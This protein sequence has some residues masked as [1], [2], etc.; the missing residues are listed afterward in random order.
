[1]RRISS[2]D[3]IVVGSGAGGLAAAAILARFKGWR[4]LVLE[5]HYEIGGL[6][7][8]FRR[9]PFSWDVGLHYVGD[10]EQGSLARGV[11]DY[12]TGG[13]LAW[14]AM[15]SDFE[16]VLLPGLD[17]KVPADLD[18][19]R[20]RLIAAFPDEAEAIRRYFRDVAHA[21]AWLASDMSLRAAPR[22]LVAA[23]RALNRLRAGPA[24][25]TTGAYL[26]RNFRSPVLKAL[27][28]YCWGD[29]GVPPS[30]SAFAI[31]ALIV[32]HYKRG[33][34]YPAGGAERFAR[35]AEREIERAGGA[36][37]VQSEVREIL[38]DGG[39]ARGVRV[40]HA[41]SGETADYFAPVVI[42][43]AGALATFRTLVSEEAHPA[44]GPLARRLAEHDSGASAIQVFLGLK[45][46]PQTLGIKGENYWLFE[47]LD[48]E[49]INEGAADLEN[50]RPLAAY[51]SFP[52]MKAG[53][54]RPPTAEILAIVAP[55]FFERWRGASDR[56]RRRGYAEA[57]TRIADGLIAIADRHIPGLKDLIEYAE[58]ATP[59]TLE[60]YDARPGGRMYGLAATPALLRSG[61]VGPRTPILGLYIAG[62]DAGS[63]GMV[64]AA[65]GGFLAAGAA[66]GFRSMGALMSELR[67]TAPAR[68]AIAH[69]PSDLPNAKFRG[70]V[71][72]RRALNPAVLELTLELD[73]AIDETP[74]RYLRIEVADAVWRDYSIAS[75]EG[76]RV[77]LLIDLRPDGPG[78][79]WARA[80]AIGDSVNLRGPIGDF[81]PREE[82]AAVHFV[83]TGTGLAPVLPMIARLG[84]TNDRRPVRLWFG[85]RERAVDLA[86]PTLAEIRL[87]RDFGVLRCFSREKS[88]PREGEFA[89]RVT[90]A[91]RE[92]NVD[93][94][95]AA[96]YVAGRPD[97]VRDVAELAPSLGAAH[98]YAEIF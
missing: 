2:F 6:T 61:L 84:A 98:V 60:H 48:H 85:C 86:T 42:S 95:D 94:R 20:D 96:F 33:G 77:R 45:D 62:N 52:A 8:S 73:R 37:L 72:A 15:P 68:R 91:L 78:A 47:T 90:D 65:M 7:H 92:A 63:L 3:A 22:P 55:E 79:K 93:W 40:A 82:G 18:A 44:V 66:V 14:N 97:M 67:K 80:C 25:E 35:L 38:I 43:D 26:D 57:K 27:L 70:R 19:Y 69:G 75:F 81:V 23:A 28:A 34:F 16:H 4:V 31:H 5:R 1:M 12:V 71:A 46:T 13:E 50:G 10:L 39:R 74:G 36:V 58:V 56:E 88:G 87:P 89:G 32:Q 76:G 64:G 49:R 51:V 17:F 29:Y 53:D 21:A 59:L 24:L 11:L 83:A 9:G 30:R 41:R 54:G